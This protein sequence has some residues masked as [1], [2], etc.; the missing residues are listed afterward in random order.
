MTTPPAGH[1]NHESWDARYAAASWPRDPDPALVALTASL[2]PGRALDLG[3]GTCRN[4]IWLSHQGWRVTGVDASRVGLDQG[5]QRAAEE[6]I[7]ITTVHRDVLAYEPPTASFDLVVVANLHFK[8]P[9]QATLFALATRALA[10][11]GHLFVVGHHLDDLGHSGPPDPE[12]LY[13]VERLRDAVPDLIVERLERQDRGNSAD[14]SP[15]SSVVLW[16]RSPLP[17]V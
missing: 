10:P 4:A 17:T 3:C 2:A 6:G 11:G 7:T 5:E 8:G 1:T 14:G 12:R 9:E 16:A 15:L 13:T